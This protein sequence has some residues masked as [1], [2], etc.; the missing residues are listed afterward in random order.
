MCVAGETFLLH[1]LQAIHPLYVAC[2][3]KHRSVARSVAL[4]PSAQG[5]NRLVRDIMQRVPAVD[6]KWTI[7][8][9]AGTEYEVSTMGFGGEVS[10]TI[11]HTLGARPPSKPELSKSKPGFTGSDRSIPVLSGRDGTPT[12]PD[13]LLRRTHSGWWTLRVG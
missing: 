6:A 1:S 2:N 10:L 11:E 13:S 3:I 5:A 9:A 8:V 7:G 4:L 12:D